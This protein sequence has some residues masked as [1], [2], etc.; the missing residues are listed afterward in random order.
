M[1]LLGRIDP[2]TWSFAAK[3]F[4]STLA[5]TLIPM[6]VVVISAL[7]AEKRAVEDEV[8][9]ALR[10]RAR[11]LADG[12]AEALYEA[13]EQMAAVAS[14][15]AA[16]DA[17]TAHGRG[18]DALDAAGLERQAQMLAREW[19]HA[20]R[21]GGFTATSADA[22]RAAI[23]IRG[24]LLPW[25]GEDANLALYDV[26][27]VPVLASGPTSVTRA[28]REPWWD[29]AWRDGRGGVHATVIAPERAQR[30]AMR[31][32]LGVPRATGSGARG[33]LVAEIPLSTLLSFLDRAPVSTG[34]RV[35]VLDG[36]GRPVHDVH[37]EAP[38]SLE[39]A[40][41][42]PESGEKTAFVK[43]GD[44]RRAGV[45]LAAI[46]PWRAARL[47]GRARGTMLEPL[48]ELRW[49]VVVEEP[50]D[51]TRVHGGRFAAGALTLLGAIA[52]CAA[53]AAFMMTRRMTKGLAGLRGAAEELAA[54][55]LDVEIPEGGADEFGKLAFAFRAMVEQQRDVVSSLREGKSQL[56]GQFRATREAKDAAEQA[57]RELRRHHEE[58][59]SWT[60]RV[61]LLGK[62]SES[63][64]DCENRDEIFETTARFG[65]QLFP[66]LTGALY[67]ADQPHASF[68]TVRVAWGPDAA[69]ERGRSAEATDCLSLRRSHAYRIE[70][71]HDPMPVCR[72]ANH[73]GLVRSLCLP[74]ITR[75]EGAIGFLHLHESAP[76]GT[77][78][79][80][81]SSTPLLDDNANRLASMVAEQLRLAIANLL[82][83][84]ELT[85]QAIRDELTG[86]YNRRFMEEALEREVERARRTRHPLSVVV[87]DIDHFKTVN[88][89]LGHAAGDAVLRGIADM[90]EAGV[91]KTD[92]A[93]RYGGEEFVLVMPNAGREDACRRV[94]E[95][96]ARVRVTTI[97]H[98]RQSLGPVTMSA[99]VASLGV[100][101][102]SPEELL[103]AADEALY[104]AKAGGRDALVVA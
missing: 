72:H 52:A 14:S 50:I 67:L 97:P 11:S 71:G 8:E 99:G 26:R 47:A 98:Q 73:P 76:L 100:N 62:L 93:C 21:E 79:R 82:L 22:R 19:N 24:L 96:L 33:V 10:T 39:R 91:R 51:A 78:V 102:E 89:R 34:G 66:G 32:A 46:M 104:R 61:D 55:K 30:S 31:I 20:P 27:G 29:D 16:A 37:T 81:A 12:V 17:L 42:L 77:T 5:L 92:F 2:R 95:V 28:H 88:D 3:L 13:L 44:G 101:G 75:R 40:Y 49:T 86:L 64:H 83:R 48:S 6:S 56:D 87:L 35:R 36:Q 18:Y 63:L 4:A 94:Q 69:R 7:L 15:R 85:R 59:R 43:L 41:E 80:H 57:H 103:R 60:A 70:R 38:S 1:K 54:G 68:Y 9:A 74:M 90:I 65:E 25:L 58:L 53:G 23:E 45:A 84:E